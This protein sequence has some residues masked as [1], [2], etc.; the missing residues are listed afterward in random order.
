MGVG[1]GR[2]SPR[3]SFRGCRYV[4]EMESNESNAVQ[5]SARSSVTGRWQP[6]CNV[7]RPAA[8]VIN[9]L[10]ERVQPAAPPLMFNSYAA[11]VKERPELDAI[12]SSSRMKSAKPVEP[13]RQVDP[14]GV[15]I[16]DAVL[17][18]C[19]TSLAVLTFTRAVSLL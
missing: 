18:L 8:A 14:M 10:P 19:D 16:R 17:F 2:S 13:L 11:G 12:R 5:P 4:G 7:K 1:A 15:V 3:V 9:G 6:R